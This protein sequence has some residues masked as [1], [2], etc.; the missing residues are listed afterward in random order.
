MAAKKKTIIQE[1][2]KTTGFVLFINQYV[3]KIY[4]YMCIIN[5]TSYSHLKYNMTFIQNGDQ[6]TKCTTT[7]CRKFKRTIV[8][9]IH[10]P[11]KSNNC[12]HDQ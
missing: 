8:V 11:S 12:F 1:F 6:N 10:R 3:C 2:N 5:N 7:F 9:M 4:T